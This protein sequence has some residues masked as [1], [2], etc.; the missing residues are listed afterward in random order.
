MEQITNYFL[1]PENGIQGIIIVVLG[2]IVVWQQRRLDSKDKQIGELQNQR[3][4]DTNVYTPENKELHAKI[5]ELENR[6]KS[7]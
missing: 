5:E 6:R 1:R 4:A 2:T 7:K 3:I